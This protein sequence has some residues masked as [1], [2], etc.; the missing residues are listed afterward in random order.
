MIS[1][2][3]LNNDNTYENRNDCRVYAKD[4]WTIGK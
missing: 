3:G 1:S 2:K 4:A